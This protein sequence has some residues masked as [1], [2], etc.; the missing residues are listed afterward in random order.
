MKKHHVPLTDAEISTILEALNRTMSEEEERYYDLGI[1]E[2]KVQEV[3]IWQE[4]HALF[5]K[6]MR[7]V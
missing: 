3:A 1:P 6:F 2:E 5:D 4:A 7:I